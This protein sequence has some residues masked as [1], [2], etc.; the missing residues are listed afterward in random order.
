VKFNKEKF[1]K[2]YLESYGG[3]FVLKGD[4]FETDSNI[5]RMGSRIQICN[6]YYPFPCYSQHRL[7]LDYYDYNNGHFKNDRALKF[8]SI[9][10][11]TKKPMIS[12]KI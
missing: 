6:K 9:S 2:V 4:T 12:M 3:F 10:E 7:S 8:I 5:I 1:Y 11:I